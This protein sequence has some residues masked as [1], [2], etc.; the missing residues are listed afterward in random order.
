MKSL[1]VLIL[2]DNPSD[3]EL[4]LHELRKEG[5]QPDWDRVETE[6]DYLEILR[7][8]Y[9][10]ILSDYSMPQFDAPRAL[11]ILSEKKFSIPFLVITGSVGENTAVQLI[12]LGAADYLIK[13]RLTRLGPAVTKAL[14]EHQVKR[15]ARKAEEAL[16]ESEK[17]YRTIFENTGTA[18]II[19]EPDHTI[20]LTNSE[21]GKQTG[22]SKDASEGKLKWTDF[23]HPDDHEQIKEYLQLSGKEE[24]A[25]PDQIKFRYLTQ[26]QETRYGYLTV[27]PIGRQGQMAASFIDITEREKAVQKLETS[28]QRYRGIFNGVQDALLVQNMIGEIVDVNQ[29]ACDIY[30]YSREEFLTKTVRD[31]V[32]EEKHDQVPSPD[33]PYTAAEE[34]TTESI[35]LRASGEQFPVEFTTRPH[36]MGGGEE[37]ILV[38]LRDISE[39]KK[40]E[41]ILERQLQETSSLHN[42][43]T[44]AT[45]ETDENVIIDQAT[46]IMGKV[47]NP[48]FYGV[49]LLDPQEKVLTVHPSY[50]NIPQELVD[51][52][53]PL[54][55]GIVG[56]VVKTGGSIYLPDVEESTQFLEIVPGIKSE[57]CVPIKVQDNVL[58]VINTEDKRPDAYSAA[59]ERFL[60]T[61]ASQLAISIQRARL[62][63]TVER[64]VNRLQT[65]R[66]ID[67]TISSSLDINITLN[68]ILEHV[69]SQ[70]EVDA[71]CI[72]LLDQDSKTLSYKKSRG[73]KT[74]ALTSTHLLVGKGYAG[75]AVL[76][77]KPVHISNLTEK[78]GKF[79]QSRYLQDENFVFYYALPLNFKG[80]IRGVL[81]L[82]N[83]SPKQV[84]QE[85]KNYA[86]T[87]GGQAA[88]AIDNA[89]M[90]EDLQ[91]TNLELSQ[92]Y[93]STLQGWAR[94]L[95]MK[96]HETEGHS[97]RVVNL[98]LAIA[99]EMNIPP[100]EMIHIRR[101]ALLHD[102]GKIAIPDKI[103]LKPGKLTEDEWEEIRKHP[104]YAE[105]M[106][107]PIQYI[108]PALDIPLSHHERW[109]G[110]GYPAGLTG[111]N[112]PLA[113][114]I[115]AVVDVWDA[116]RSDRPYRKAWSQQ[117][118]I[119]Y[120]KENS[121]K[122]FD[123]RVVRVF[124]KKIQHQ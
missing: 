49:L 15:Q 107:K 89:E 37:V 51:V 106:L 65:L 111:E 84:P 112:I 62:Y 27:S 47:L 78:P 117:Q 100:E 33:N 6:N 122:E 58:G 28:E 108:T 18:T 30:G 75:Q 54:N 124:L 9:D 53:V 39:R 40:R 109:D 42:L 90:F 81:E 61:L 2:E 69:L 77:N 70:L 38:G 16:K 11:E 87:L 67:R 92:A 101:G 116:L 96:D 71:A 25:P 7:P 48:E 113:A 88:I 55:K 74:S 41:Q 91:S 76:E 20:S 34:F 99:R 31:L 14:E 66:S 93:D 60:V 45:V 19:I 114:R 1:K 123:P 120:I 46:E 56:Q 63:R 103:L 94:A 86:D 85:W 72:L 23:V 32:P 12:K 43:A 80:K 105:K 50:R 79:I 104:L 8:D 5:Y 98:T 59:D 95:E 36:L 73:F 115:F 21:F 13:D 118:A 44:T 57:L 24:Q 119:Q 102:V 29:Q 4:M 35:H 17:R 64:Q 26:D 110:S 82:F 22:Y 83:R 52:K 68:I 3:A 10:I 121:G 97:K